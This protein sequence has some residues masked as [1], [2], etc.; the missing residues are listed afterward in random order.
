MMRAV[1]KP[2]SVLKT[3]IY[4]VH[5]SRND[6]SVQYPEFSGPPQYSLFELASDGACKAYDLRHTW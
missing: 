4:L 2:G 1:H 6:F 3:I 5:S